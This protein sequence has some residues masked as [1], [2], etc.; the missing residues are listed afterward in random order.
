VLSTQLSQCHYYDSK[1]TVEQHSVFMQGVK[2]EF[3]AV[4]NSSKVT[5][6]RKGTPDK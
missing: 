3:E 2:D 5:K 4:L 6:K 1:L